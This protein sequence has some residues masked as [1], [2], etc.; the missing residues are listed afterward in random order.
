[1]VNDVFTGNSDESVTGG[2]GILLNGGTYIIDDN[3]FYENAPLGGGGGGALLSASTGGSLTLY[4]NIFYN[5]FS[6]D[7]DIRNNT[8][9]Y[10]QGNNSFSTTNPR[11]VNKNNPIGPDSIWAT[12][13][14]GLQLSATSPAIN[15][16]NTAYIPIG[17]G[18]DITGA[19]RVVGGTVD[20][21][22]YETVFAKPAG[23]TYNTPD[24]FAVGMPITQLS[25]SS[26][27]GPVFKYTVS[28][29]L[30]AGLVI[31]SVTG[32]ISG[33]PG[34]ASA[35]AGYA[36]TASNTGGGSTDTIQIAVIA[37]PAG[38]TYNTPDSIGQGTPVTPLSPSSSGGTITKYKVS[39]ALPAGLVIDSVTG[40][41]SGTPGTASPLAGYVITGSNFAGNTTF[42]IQIAVIAPPAG[43]AYNT[44]D[45]FALHA[46]IA[47]LSP[48]SSGG[49]VFKYTVSPAL[50]EGLVID[51][52]TGIIS[53]TPGAAS[54]LAGYVITGSNFAGNTTFTIQIA[55][56]A[57]PAG[58]TYPTPN[59][60]LTGYFITPITPTSS[61]GAI[62]NYTISPALPQGLAIDSS[63]GSIGGITDA[64]SPTTS[65]VITGSNSA[66]STADTIQIT[67]R[68]EFDWQGSSDSNWNNPQNWQPNGV[69]GPLDVAVV[70][71]A[72]PYFPVISE[73]DS[74]YTLTVSNYPTLT[75]AKGGNL[76]ILSDATV[77][78]GTFVDASTGT[79]NF[80]GTIPQNVTGVITADT[81][82]VNNPAGVTLA[83]YSGPVT[84][85]GIYT[86][87]AGMLNSNGNL[88]LAS[89]ASGTA[90]VAQGS[91][92]YIT[93]NVT[94][95]RY[96]PAHRAWRFITAPLSNTGSIYA[97]WQNGGIE[98]DSTGVLMFSPGGTGGG[99]NGLTP[100][101]DNPSIQ[102]YNPLA[103]NWVGLTNTTSTLLSGT[104]ASAANNAYGVFV[105]GPY[106]SANI[107]PATGA[108]A[109]TL[110]ATG[111]LQTGT[112]TFNYSSLAAGNYILVGNPY[113]SPVN[114]ANIGA[115][116]AAGGNIHN[117]MWAWDA[118]RS[119]TRYGG[120][121]TFSWDATANSYDQDIP[122]AQTAQ[123]TVI[124][125]GEA[126]FVQ[127]ANNGMATITVNETDKASPSTI[128]GGVFG[129]LGGTPG[130]AKQMRI[131]L[132]RGGGNTFTAVDG[133]LAKFGGSYSKGVDDDATK[134]FDY[135]E[136]LSLQINTSHLSI[137]RRPLPVPGDTLF[138][139]TNALKKDTGYAFT[140][141]PLNIQATGLQAWLVDKYLGTETQVS[142][143]DST[144]ISFNTGSDTGSL[145]QSRFIVV[146][147]A[148][149]TLATTLSNVKAWPAGNTIQV[150]WTAPSEL[151]V[152]Q[153]V[154]ERSA[155]GQNFIPLYSTA[156]HNSGRTEVYN[157]VDA[158]PLGGENYYRIEVY[159]SDG[160]TSYS[161]VALVKASGR[162]AAFS[163]YPN[164]VQKSR[165]LTA[166]F[167]NMAA[168]RYMLQVYDNTGK[169]LLN[170]QIEYDGTAGTQTVT[171]PP[172]LAAG[173]YRLVLLDGNGKLWKLQ[174]MVQ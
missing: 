160:T 35:W 79:I 74:V 169:Q 91:G 66:G 37:P 113:A 42:T 136:N 36:V 81:L 83:P 163:V 86:S 93:G 8:T 114:F 29:A 22:A 161:N 120:Y 141:S 56:I 128:H 155:N 58:L 156:A 126:F 111:Q 60:L 82:T 20:L 69:P 164:P 24:S 142:L 139:N 19:P 51:S 90:A 46:V 64:A 75:V 148:N 107:T 159:N 124:Q 116:G 17:I 77:A 47:P 33:T 7:V 167:T 2:G 149:G 15:A 67:V 154:V 62:T 109:T 25:P 80:S 133:V 146:F 140:F 165:Q 49:L 102:A 129:L 55:V 145:S 73:R 72:S 78:Y 45:S 99:G 44:P 52:V 3:T 118:Q 143:S 18:G 144:T 48:S 150:E 92:N 54:P 125:S 40:I 68:T 50:P 171:L 38:L 132:N 115:A 122:A 84:V 53:G 4:N 57:P 96:I 108:A 147:I 137:E 43:L 71:N 135:D 9:N 28:P 95:Q 10:K 100:G 103:N 32:I 21:G 98:T 23:L 151:G 162:P 166:L 5:D 39:P 12:A 30:P 88:V 119:G 130:N 117:T 6:D 14:D 170:K 87:V 94:V 65:Y 16:G 153:Y 174:L 59:S 1:M 121:V 27:G 63:T 70:S 97:N 76:T 173:S 123:T 104:A 61:G 138:L 106:G 85:T 105:T 158:L 152:N 110:L 157:W 112:Q 134:L 31:D 26:S 101:G 13:D 127:A 89:S 34:A 131:V 168:G 11:F 41:I 172:G